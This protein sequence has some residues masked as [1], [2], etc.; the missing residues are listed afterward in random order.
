MFDSRIDGRPVELEQRDCLVD[1]NQKSQ[2][3]KGVCQ[4]GSKDPEQQTKRREA[5]GLF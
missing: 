5:P 3:E 4:D 1:F 2:H